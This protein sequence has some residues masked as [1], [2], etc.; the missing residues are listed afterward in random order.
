[1]LFGLIVLNASYFAGVVWVLRSKWRRSASGAACCLPVDDQA[2]ASAVGWPP[3]GAQFGEYV[4][5]GFGALDTY[6]S[7]ATPPE[8][9]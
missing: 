8:I 3:E 2:P 9:G 1:M 4:D 7:A 5:E 6:L